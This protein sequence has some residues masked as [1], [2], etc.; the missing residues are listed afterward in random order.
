MSLLVLAYPKIVQKDYDWIQ[1][2]RKKYDGY[3]KIVQPHFT[4]VFPVN[5]FEESIFIRHTEN[6][7]KDFKQIE[8]SL[9][10]STIVKDS[11]SDFSHIFIVPDEGNSQIIKLHDKLY[12][13]VLASELR[14][15]I[16]FIPHIA[17]GGSKIPEECKKLSDKLNK[18]GFC[19]KGTINNLDLTFY[20][21][22]EVKT[23]K[24]IILRQ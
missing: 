1:R 11:F 21:Y 9:R 22:P 12:S 5:N 16:P 8:F 19:I 18:I 24:K 10:C 14:L 7:L 13:D 15:D 2:F 6:I 17:I 23:I 20:N 3:Y 4:L